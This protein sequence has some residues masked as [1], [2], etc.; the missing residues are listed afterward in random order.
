[1]NFKR[2]Y[3]YLCVNIDVPT[4]KLNLL[5]HFKKHKLLL[6]RPQIKIVS[7][8]E[9]R[10]QQYRGIIPMK[11]QTFFQ[12]KNIHI[13]NLL[14]FQNLTFSHFNCLIFTKFCL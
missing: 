13:Q 4:C 7:M 10:D 14:N 8:V 11:K 1:M 9:E 12:N 3:V 2:N 6:D 5:N